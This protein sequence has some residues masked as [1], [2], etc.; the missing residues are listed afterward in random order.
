MKTVINSLPSLRKFLR[1]VEAA[2]NEHKFLRVNIKAGVDR[3][4]NQNSISHA[5]YNDIALQIADTAENV[6]C[7]CKLR[8]G[9]PILCAE[10]EDFMEFYEA[11]LKHLTYAQQLN[12]MR[13]VPVT[14]LM[15]KKQLTRYLEHVQQEYAKQGVVVSF[16]DQMERCA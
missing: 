13:F 5:W 16:P 1:D 11:S 15:T 7:E 3:S 4:I 8:W 9:V 2:F 14:S 6:K 12:A 10:D